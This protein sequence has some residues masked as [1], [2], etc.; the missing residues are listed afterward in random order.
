MLLIGSSIFLASCGASYNESE[1]RSPK[2][3]AKV[4]EN[5]LDLKTQTN[6]KLVGKKTIIEGVVDGVV[7]MTKNDKNYLE[8]CFGKDGGMFND[9]TV[10]AKF[11]VND[12]KAKEIKEGDKIKIEATIEGHSGLLGKGLELKD[13][14][15]L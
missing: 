8:V 10:V 6:D 7:N 11:D 9:C 15:I 2:D 12:E 14:K 4:Y 3:L 5:T 13:C 1:V